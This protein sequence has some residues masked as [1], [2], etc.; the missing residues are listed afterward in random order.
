MTAR[1]A[2]KGNELATEVTVRDATRGKSACN[3]SDSERRSKNSK[4]RASGSVLAAEVTARDAARTQ[5]AGR[6]SLQQQ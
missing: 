6:L 5:K 3:R 1:D 4:G 2:T